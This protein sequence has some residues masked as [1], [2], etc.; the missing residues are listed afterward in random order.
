ME[1]LRDR[2]IFII[3]ERPC[4][5]APPLDHSTL[6]RRGSN[7]SSL[8]VAIS[9]PAT[10]LAAQTPPPQHLRGVATRHVASATAMSVPTT[11]T[12]K[13]QPGPYGNGNGVFRHS[14]GV[15]QGFRSAFSGAQ[16]PSGGGYHGSNNEASGGGSLAIGSVH[17]SS[18]QAC[19][20]NRS[21]PT[22]PVK[23]QCGGF[24][25]L[26]PP[27]PSS[28]HGHRGTGGSSSS[29]PSTPVRKCSSDFLQYTGQ[30]GSASYLG[31]AHHET[32][33]HR[34][35]AHSDGS[36]G[37]RLSGG[38]DFLG[39][40]ASGGRRLSSQGHSRSASGE[41]QGSPASGNPFRS[42][43]SA[44]HTRRSSHGDSATGNPASPTTT[45]T[46]TP[47][48]SNGNHVTGKPPMGTYGRAIAA[49]PYGKLVERVQKGEYRQT[50]ARS[51]LLTSDSSFSQATPT[52]GHV[53]G[54][55]STGRRP[56]SLV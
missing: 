46:T 16:V 52:F 19:V 28:R 21:A 11:P 6:R 15:A 38:H 30:S 7:R 54:D 53:T 1:F 50:Q 22:T 44:S 24:P 34:G 3:A 13:Q 39:G 42:E 5:R 47:A 14:D 20:T 10:P 48:T 31:H 32:S 27:P 43:S 12:C 9:L 18:A 35:S 36:A 56:L 2:A 51:L 26:P 37:L 17:S 41:Q 23:K 40:G 4:I 49:P 33:H 8:A 29:V 55:T 25:L 45:T